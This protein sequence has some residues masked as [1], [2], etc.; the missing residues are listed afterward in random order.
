V[1]QD[2]ISISLIERTTSVGT[3]QLARGGNDSGCPV[4]V[5]VAPV[6]LHFSR[7]QSRVA[8][9]LLYSRAVLHLAV[10]NNSLYAVVYRTGSGTGGFS[11]ILAHSIVHYVRN[12]STGLLPQSPSVVVLPSSSLGDV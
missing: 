7:T 6:P 10:A 5:D 4:Q 8:C 3:S 9:H 12:P 1:G 11:L 2:G